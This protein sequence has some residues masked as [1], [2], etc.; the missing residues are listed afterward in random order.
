MAPNSATSFIAVPEPLLP[1][2]LEVRVH[3]ISIHHQALHTHTTCD[4]ESD[5]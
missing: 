4:N 2:H 5:R 3:H 1:R